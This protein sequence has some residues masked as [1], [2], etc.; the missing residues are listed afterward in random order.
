MDVTELL[1][2]QHRQVD[3]L[4]ERYATAADTDAKA[5]IAREIVTLLAKHS[6]V[7]EIEVYPAIGEVVGTATEEVLNEQH[8]HLKRILADVEHC[9]G[10]D[11]RMDQLVGDARAA[12]RAHV[13][14]EENEVFAAF[15]AQVD[16]VTLR[17]LAR[18]VEDRWDRAPTHPH[19]NQPP[20]NRVTG[21][22]VGLVD[23]A[24]DAFRREERSSS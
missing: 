9:A 2:A 14:V 24:R 3:A 1:T 23:R 12:V 10:G 20:A 7:E 22:V 6:A 5:A 17:E 13:A 11:E 18:K 8:M 16:D 19:P 21:P 4:F 15:R